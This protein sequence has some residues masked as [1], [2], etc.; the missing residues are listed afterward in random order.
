M[1]NPP[2]WRKDCEACEGEGTIERRDI[3]LHHL[4]SETPEYAIH[5]CDQCDGEGSVW[6]D[7]PVTL[8]ACPPGPFWFDGWL[9]F[10]TE[11]NALLADGRVECPGHLIRWKMSDWPDAYC[12]KSGEYFWGGTKTHEERANLLVWPVERLLVGD[13]E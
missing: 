7:E 3:S 12:M 1:E 10:K 11:Y 2:E 9:G 8:A 6:T 13:P 4:H 5:Q